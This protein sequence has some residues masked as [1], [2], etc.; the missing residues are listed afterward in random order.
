MGGG[1]EFLYFDFAS[2]KTLTDPANLSRLLA[3][4]SQDE[5]FR[6]TDAPPLQG[7]RVWVTF[8]N[9]SGFTMSFGAEVENPKRLYFLVDT[10]ELYEPQPAN[11]K[12]MRSIV[13]A[14]ELIYLTLHPLYGYGLTSPRLHKIPPADAKVRALYTYNFF[15]PALIKHFGR[16]RILSVPAWRR[17]E[18]DDGGLLLE[19][20]PLPVVKHWEYTPKFEQGAKI[21]RVERFFQIGQHD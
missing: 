9:R 6:L 1:L 10:S 12:N 16:E 3:R 13:R 8:Q 4:L 21:L 7:G 15:S 11:L 2:D 18:F 20:S 17:V 5:E 14:C 19:M